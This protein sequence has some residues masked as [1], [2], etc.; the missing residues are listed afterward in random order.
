MEKISRRQKPNTR[1]KTFVKWWSLFSLTNKQHHYIL[2]LCIQFGWTA[3]HHKSGREIADLKALDKWM[4]SDKCPVQKPLLKMTRKE[5]SKIIF[6]LE[7]M[8]TKKH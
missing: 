7:E 4:R 1:E 5:T 6:A 3:Q 2:S 8:V